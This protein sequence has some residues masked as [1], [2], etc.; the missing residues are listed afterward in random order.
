MQSTWEKLV[1]VHSR[2]DY[3]EQKRMRVYTTRCR[4]ITE[5]AV[6]P[7]IDFSTALASLNAELY[8]LWAEKRYLLQELKT[9]ESTSWISPRIPISLDSRGPLLMSKKGTDK[10]L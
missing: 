5:G 9:S 6:G 7:S 2:I 1:E 8:E 10:S 4:G 3:L